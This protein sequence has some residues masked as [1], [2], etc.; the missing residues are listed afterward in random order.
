M[1]PIYFNDCFGWFHPASGNRGVVICSATGVEDLCTHR[2]MR[3]WA[4]Q[5]ALAGVPTLRFD[6]HGNGDSLGTDL[7]ADRVRHWLNS[8]KH[9]IQWLRDHANV[10]EV[11]LVGFRLGGLLAYETAVQSADISHLV[12]L[13]APTTGKSYLREMKALALLIDGMMRSK[14]DPLA[15]EHLEVA[16]FHLTAQTRNELGALDMLAHRS[17]PAQQ[18]LIMG[19]AESAS[20]K[21]LAQHLQGLGCEVN[22]AELLGYAELKWDSSF[23]R[24]PDDAFNGVVQWLTQGMTITQRPAPQIETGVLL[25]DA[26]QEQPVHFGEQ[27]RLFGIWCRPIAEQRAATRGKVVLF[28]NHGANHHIGWA[29]MHVTLAR[30]FAANGIASLRLDISG[31]GDSPAHPGYREN[32]LYARHSQLDVHAAVSWLESEG[33]TLITV[34]GHCAGAYLGFYSTL[35]D[36]RVGELVMLNLQRFFWARDE[37]LESAMRSSF[38]SSTWYWSRLRD[39]NTWRRL[40]SARIDVISIGRMILLRTKQRAYGITAGALGALLGKRTLSGKVV[41]WLRSLSMRGT[42]VLL[43]YSAQDG[44]LDELATY[45]GP[46]GRR[47][48]KLGNIEIKV[49]EGADHNL[50]QHWSQQH[51][52]ELLEKFLLKNASNEQPAKP[53]ATETK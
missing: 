9:A 11:A 23:A 46:N 15:D 32:M 8:C 17:L 1:T 41:N 28:V 53:H 29:R 48:R 19:R 26:W 43:V 14:R 4:E 34:I 2:F 49:I 3:R 10:T 37:V 36:P 7:D 30:R 13:A 20:D 6:Y 39:A 33:Y 5:L 45:A 52:A 22:T 40:L 35:R 27:R 25:G 18:V 44:G 12:L 51:Y 47:I 42:R 21:R 24:F 50:T 16:G 38:Q 31:V